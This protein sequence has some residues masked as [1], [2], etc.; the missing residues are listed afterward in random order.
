VEATEV[1]ARVT[2][3]AMRDQQPGDEPE[4][5]ARRRAVGDLCARLTD[6]PGIAAMAATIAADEEKDRWHGAGFLIRQLGFEGEL[7]Q[8]LFWL[9]GVKSTRG[10]AGSKYFQ[11]LQAAACEH[12]GVATPQLGAE[13]S[14]IYEEHGDLL[15]RWIVVQHEPTAE[16]LTGI[17]EVVL[18]RGD[19]VHGEIPS[20]P[21][22]LNLWPL[23]SFATD[24][25][26]AASFAK[27][28]HR[29]RGGTPSVYSPIVPVERISATPVTGAANPLEHEV[30][31]L[32]GNPDDLATITRM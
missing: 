1:W 6:E 22:H 8:V 15:R 25:A 23:A 20:S 3:Q 4:W 26:T 7:A 30:V 32:T 5:P 18:H 2:E 13:A 31:L 17:D 10:E 9:I 11:A 14:T 24:Y 28:A 21:T 16:L 12:A 19:I 27:R 29:C